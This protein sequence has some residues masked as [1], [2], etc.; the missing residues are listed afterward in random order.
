MKQSH[1]LYLVDKEHTPPVLLIYGS[2]DHYVP[3]YSTEEFIEVLE[4]KGITYKTVVV[5][6]SDHVF[7]LMGGNIGSQIYEQVSVKWFGQY[8]K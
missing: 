2:N 5:S 8:N 3:R 7:D 6:F 1:L 4:E